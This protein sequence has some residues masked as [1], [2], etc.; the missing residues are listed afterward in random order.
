MSRCPEC[1][2]R[3]TCARFCGMDVNEIDDEFDEVEAFSSELQ[4]KNTKLQEELEAQL[5]TY[6]KRCEEYH[7]VDEENKVL[8]DMI[9][10]HQKSVENAFEERNLYKKCLVNIKKHME[11]VLETDLSRR[12]S[13]VW[14]MVDKC[15]K[16]Q[17]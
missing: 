13:V 16:E 12:M 1:N 14:L 6:Y 15:L 7:E 9:K 4:T 11:I 3:G 8:S 10:S 2:C 17:E 5:I